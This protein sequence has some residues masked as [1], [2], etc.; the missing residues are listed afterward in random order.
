MSDYPHAP[1]EPWQRM[2]WAR[3]HAGF[4]RAIAAAEAL[5]IGPNTY[6]SWERSVEDGGRWP[7]SL[8]MLQRVARKFNVNW[9]WLATGVGEPLSDS[10]VQEAAETFSAKVYELAPDKRGDA[11]RAAIAVLESYRRKA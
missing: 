9:T 8:A 7:S 5:G 2:R 1:S 10:E 3:Q 6:R 11:V 4:R